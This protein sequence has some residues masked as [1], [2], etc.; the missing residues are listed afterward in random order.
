M[1]LQISNMKVIP[2]W[3]WRRDEHYSD[4]DRWVLQRSCKFVVTAIVPLEQILTT[5]ASVLI[6][7]IHIRQPTSTYLNNWVPPSLTAQPNT[8][9]SR[10]P[11]I[12]GCDYEDL[13]AVVYDWK[14]SDAYYRKSD[15]DQITH[16]IFELTGQWDKYQGVAYGVHRRES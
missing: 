9:Y 8:L 10:S 5:A 16:T 3:R 6:A 13:D 7:S 4:R 14:V 15:A 1:L 2:L 11:E 12:S